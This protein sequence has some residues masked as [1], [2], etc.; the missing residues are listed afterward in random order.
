MFVNWNYA[1]W[2]E[3]VIP[4]SQREDEPIE[5]ATVTDEQEEAERG[6]FKDILAQIDEYV[7][8]LVDGTGKSETEDELEQVTA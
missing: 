3:S 4:E 5:K 7:Q 2:D 1:R 8:S 6:D